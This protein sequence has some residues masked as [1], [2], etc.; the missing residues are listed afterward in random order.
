MEEYPKLLQNSIYTTWKAGSPRQEVGLAM[1]F[2]STNH[3][4]FDSGQLTLDITDGAAIRYLASKVGDESI[5]VV[6][7]T[8]VTLASTVVQRITPELSLYLAPGHLRRA[9]CLRIH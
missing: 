9:R 8:W 2:V 3:R 6:P 4:E 1:T 5:D 7:T